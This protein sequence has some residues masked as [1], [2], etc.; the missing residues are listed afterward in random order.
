M[1]LEDGCNLLVFVKFAHRQ[2]AL[3]DFRG[4]VGV[5]TQKDD[6]VVLDLE[7]EPAVYSA[8]TCHASFYFFIGHS[9][10]VCQC[11]GGYAV[12]YVDANRN[13]QL[14]IVDTG[15]RGNKVDE[16]FSVSDANVFCME[17]AFVA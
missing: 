3:F 15:V 2:H 12:F 9:V 4:V 10:K 5:V 6:T 13:S 7:V 16:Y 17:V 1:R 8:E 11:H 14:N